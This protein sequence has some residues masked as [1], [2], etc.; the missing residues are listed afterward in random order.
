M[1]EVKVKARVRLPQLPNFLLFAGDESKDMKLDVAD[2]SDESLQQI[3]EQWTKA[4][5]EHAR[6]RRVK[7]EGLPE[8]R[9]E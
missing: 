4:L 5:I 1:V 3:G 7:H 6:S 8:G 9:S 2:A